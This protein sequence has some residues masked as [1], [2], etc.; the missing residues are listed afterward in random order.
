MLGS[1]AAEFLPMQN[2]PFQ[3][4]LR[5]P[6]IVSPVALVAHFSETIHTVIGKEKK[7]HRL[8]KFTVTDEIKR[9]FVPECA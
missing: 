1:A 5:I 7:I 3:C 9:H 2:P 8:L 6:Y 4:L